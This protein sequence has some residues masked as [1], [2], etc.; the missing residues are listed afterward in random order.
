ML[1]DQWCFL[2]ICAGEKA[3]VVYERCLSSLSQIFPCDEKTVM[4]RHEIGMEEAIEVF[5]KETVMDSDMENFGANLEKLT[6]YY[7]WLLFINTAI[8]HVKTAGRFWIVTI[9]AFIHVM[10]PCNWTNVFERFLTRNLKP[11]FLLERN[12]SNPCNLR[13][14]REVRNTHT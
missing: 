11:S 10:H 9:C 3:L 7:Q 12:P 14:I 2:L 1:W 8:L 4:E 13:D 5:R 6:V